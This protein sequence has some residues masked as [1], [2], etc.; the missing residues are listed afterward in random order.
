MLVP[1]SSV[2]RWGLQNQMLTDK[3]TDK[4]TTVTLIRA[5]AL[6]VNWLARGI[7]GLENKAHISL[8]GI[9]GDSLPALVLTLLKY[10]KKNLVD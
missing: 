10:F 9:W 5:C 1:I 3:Q 7:G 8:F 2:K 6:R 4:L